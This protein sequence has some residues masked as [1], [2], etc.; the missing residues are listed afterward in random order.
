MESQI[1][2][3]LG[4]RKQKTALSG[5]RCVSD[6]QMGAW[7]Q[8]APAAA[9]AAARGGGPWGGRVEPSVDFGYPWNWRKERRP[10]T[11][12]CG[13]SYCEVHQHVDRQHISQC[14]T[15]LVCLL[16]HWR[17]EKQDWHRHGVRSLQVPL[18][19]NPLVALR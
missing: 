7:E 6:I 1:E 11:G 19:C 14:N 15:V 16:S 18:A 13:H 4:S 10:C 12:V 3:V 2:T 8:P 17:C 9:A 5:E